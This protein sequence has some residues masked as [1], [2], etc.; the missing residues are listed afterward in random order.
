MTIYATHA[1]ASD[2]LAEHAHSYDTLLKAIDVSEG[3][4]FMNEDDDDDDDEEDMMRNAAIKERVDRLQ[5]YIQTESHRQLVD[6]FGE[7][8]YQVVLEIRFP[9]L[10]DEQRDGSL[11]IEMAPLGLMP[12]SKQL[13]MEQIFHGLWN[14]CT[15]QSHKDGRIGATA[16]TP[17][18]LDSKLQQFKDAELDSV[19][20]QEYD[21]N[22]PHSLL[23]VGF[24]G[25]PGGPSWY[26]NTRDNEEAHGP[27]GSKNVYALT[28]EADPCFG[29]VVHGFEVVEKLQNVPVAPNGFYTHYPVIQN[30]YVKSEHPE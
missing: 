19:S 29:R 11:T 15:F 25:R 7:G 14:G 1:S 5:K 9:H 10:P 2:A 3:S 24:D 6:R 21:E 20:F 28:D 18:S 12:H 26:I 17:D 16:A 30:A 22:F 27:G 23:T 13:F 4:D 8:P